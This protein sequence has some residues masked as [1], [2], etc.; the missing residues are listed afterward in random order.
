MH[1]KRCDRLRRLHDQAVE[2]SLGMV[3]PFAERM[4]RRLSART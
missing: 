3:A 4:A 1:W 2:R